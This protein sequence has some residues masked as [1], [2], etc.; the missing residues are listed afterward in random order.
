[1]KSL[2]QRVQAIEDLQA[3]MNLKTR[4]LDLANGGWDKVSHEGEKIAALFTEDGHWELSDWATVKGRTKIRDTFDKWSSEIPFAYH[5]VSNPSVE[6]TGDTAKGKWNLLAMSTHAGKDRFSGEDI[7][8]LAVYN[9]EFMRVNDRWLFSKL[10]AQIVIQ[11]PAR[12]ENWSK[13][14]A[15][16]HQPLS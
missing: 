16:F 14:L 10:H 9:D 6:V 4:Y 11:G 2:E 3:I 1:M 8:T 12:G 5:M 13:F 7:M 15:K